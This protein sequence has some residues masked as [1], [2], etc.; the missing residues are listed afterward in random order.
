MATID[1][2]MSIATQMQ[3]NNIGDTPLTDG[4]SRAENVV[5]FVL[6]AVERKSCDSY[7]NCELIAE[8]CGKA[9][10]SGK[11]TADLTNRLCRRGRAARRVSPRVSN[12][13]GFESNT[14]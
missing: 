10:E 7:Y 12:N 9:S 5:P 13:A 11:E 14:V 2:E 6:Q 4:N 3:Q 1:F 8:K